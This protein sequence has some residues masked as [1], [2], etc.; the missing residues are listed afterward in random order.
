MQKY[1]AARPEVEKRLQFCKVDGVVS[2]FKQLNDFGV[3]R[4]LSVKPV[5][6]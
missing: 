3:A 4:S 1:D 6:S 2:M 5:K